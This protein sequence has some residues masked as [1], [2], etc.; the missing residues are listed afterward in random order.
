[1]SSWWFGSE[2]GTGDGASPQPTNCIHEPH[3]VYMFSKRENAVGNPHGRLEVRGHTGEVGI[4]PCG[5]V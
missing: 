4:L 1:M 2:E 5:R 3:V